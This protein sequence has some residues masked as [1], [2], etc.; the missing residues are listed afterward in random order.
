[1]KQK[2]K[3]KWLDCGKEFDVEADAFL[4]GVHG[5]LS[6]QDGPDYVIVDPSSPKMCKPCVYLRIR[7][8]VEKDIPVCKE[9]AEE[10]QENA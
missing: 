3:F 10:I 5:T 9:L 7:E 1:M 2:R 4:P 8:L 6:Q